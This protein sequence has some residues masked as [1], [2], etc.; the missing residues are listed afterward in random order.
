MRHKPTLMLSNVAINRLIIL[1]FM[2]LV[3]FSLAKSVSSGS[4]LGLILAI[5]SLGAGV[6]FL[7]LLTRINE[8]EKENII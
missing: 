1:G 2:V 3:G 7:Y 6:Y 5:T 4:T 8:T